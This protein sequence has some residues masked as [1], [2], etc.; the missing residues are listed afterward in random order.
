[1]AT[2]KRE[3]IGNLHDK[4]VVSLEKGDFYPDFEK[5]L[6]QY[7]R[8]VSMPGFRKGNVPVGMVRKMYGPSVFAD[9][10]S[11]TANEQLNNYLQENKPNIFA[12]PMIMEGQQ[13][14]LDMN[15]TDS[16][17]IAFEMAL[18]PEFE[19]TPLKD[20]GKV[21]RYNVEVNDELVNKEL[22][23]LRRRTGE[24]TH[25][26]SPEEDSDMVYA[27]YIQTDKDGTPLEGATANEDVVT[28]EQLPEQLA[29]KVKGQKA[30]FSLVF[31]PSKM[32][33]EDKLEEFMK[34]ALKS[35]LAKKEDY[36]KFTLTK[37]GRLLPSDL[38]EDFYAKVFP[39]EAIKDENQFKSRLKEELGKES[40]K[41][42]LTRLENELFEKLVHETQ[43]DLPIAFLKNWL[44]RGGEELK[45]DDQVEAEFPNF[46]HQLRWTL[47]SEKLI[48][49]F[50]IQ[51]T[52]EEVKEELKRNVLTYFG[53]QDESSMPWLNE[54]LE[55][56]AQDEKTMNETYQRLLF[57]KLFAEVAQRMEVKEQL[58]SDEEFAKL[59]SADHHHHH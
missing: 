19:V 58:V 9:V 41:A 11:K 24:L 16:V 57:N 36:F 32:V 7:S 30:D 12:Q 55:R 3:S 37:T 33:E 47:I 50:D 15:K 54:Y 56:M 45:T 29:K 23:N 53:G 31:Q 6:K 51:V 52:P 18:K 10:V 46:E 21:V 39:N 42:G 43:I 1:M 25:P 26:E 27:T 14:N 13:L 5:T 38:N 48:K 8:S 17:E 34:F 20:K 2:V 4:L 28:L 35:D 49:D 59:Q 44:K 40:D 22:E